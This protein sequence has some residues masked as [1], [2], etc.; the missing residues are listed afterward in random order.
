M[1][2][3][4]LGSTQRSQHLGYGF[5]PRSKLDLFNPGLDKEANEEVVAFLKWMDRQDHSGTATND[6]RHSAQA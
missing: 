2:K 5:K 6:L 4:H 3:A 1:T